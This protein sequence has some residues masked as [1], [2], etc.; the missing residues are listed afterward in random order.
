MP[1]AAMSRSAAA[2][3]LAAGEEIR[4]SSSDLRGRVLQTSLQI[5]DVDGFAG[6][7]LQVH[8]HAL[9]LRLDVDR[10]NLRV[11]RCRAGTR[12]RCTLGELV[13]EFLLLSAAHRRADANSVLRRLD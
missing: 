11:L 7:E 1:L 3:S 5:E 4:S 10:L 2:G 6:P 12:T 9:R 13:Q 8:R